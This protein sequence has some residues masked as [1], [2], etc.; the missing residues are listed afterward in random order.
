MDDVVGQLSNT[1]PVF[2]ELRGMTCCDAREYPLDCTADEIGHQQQ[3]KGRAGGDDDQV[4]CLH[5]L[6]SSAEPAVGIV[7]ERPAAGCCYLG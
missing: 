2:P 4:L 6:C 7:G 5:V 1:F 3:P